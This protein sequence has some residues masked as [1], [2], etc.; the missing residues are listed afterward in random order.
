MATSSK[1]QEALALV[2][3]AVLANAA[4]AADD[5]SSCPKLTLHNLCPY[6]VWPL[7]TA[8]AG[9]PSVAGTDARLDGNGEGLVTMALP[10]GAWSGR[11][12]ARTGCADDGMACGDGCS[13]PQCET[14]N[15][16]PAT[17]AQVSVGGYGG[18]AVY[19]V[20]LVDGFNVPMV[21]TPSD[22]AAGA[23]CPTLGCAVDLTQDQE[24]CP[25]GA[26]APHGGCGAGGT[27][28]ALFKAKCPDTRTTSTDV[29]ATPQDC[30]A[31]GELK[32]VFCPARDCTA[33]CN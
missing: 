10:Q 25:A 29:E 9:Y 26:G 3:L 19:S 14:G 20:S 33:S 7:V 11:V 2:A 4:V 23:Q 12:V 32:V 17:V 21:V 27:Q 1:T 18:L 16:P 24:C 13:P 8:N 31:P 5:A 22:F 30:I 28:A 6:P 15:A